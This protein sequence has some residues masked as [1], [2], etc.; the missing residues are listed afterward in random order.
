MHCYYCTQ[1]TYVYKST[2]KYS[3]ALFPWVVG[4]NL[5][6][7][8]NSSGVFGALPGWWY[9]KTKNTINGWEK[10]NISAK[11]TRQP[12]KRM[13][14]LNDH[15]FLLG[16]KICIEFSLTVLSF[17]VTWNDCATK[18]SSLRKCSLSHREQDEWNSNLNFTGAQITVLLSFLD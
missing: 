5:R 7:H 15:P 11:L 9:L 13:K 16:F 3:T 10:Q 14:Q 12:L 8:L 18:L 17:I 4:V 1:S 6:A 2:D